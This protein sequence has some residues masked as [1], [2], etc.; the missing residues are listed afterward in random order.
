MKNKLKHI[1]FGVLRFLPLVICIAFM[2]FFLFGDKEVTVDT[3]LDFT[4]RNPILAAIFMVLMYSFKS[5]TVFFP[6]TVLNIAGGFIFPPP[7]A[8]LVNS[9][10]VIAEL[11]IPYWIGRLSGAGFADKLTKKHPKIA[12]LS[13]FGTNGVFFKSFFLRVI[14]ILP[15]DAVSMYLG[16]KKLPFGIYLLGSFLGTFPTMVTATLLGTSIT[17]PT[18]PIFWISFILTIVL[19]VASVLIFGIG[20]KHKK[21]DTPADSNA[22]SKEDQSC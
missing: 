13:R 16:A 10:G 18:S 22:V 11:T 17:D 3:L 9:V 5:L 7:V 6:I 19:S 20:L 2:L 15:G 1:L 4:P 14:S 12:E 8:L 21:E